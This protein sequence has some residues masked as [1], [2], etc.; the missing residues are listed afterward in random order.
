M[1][2]PS[3]TPQQKAFVLA[4]VLSRPATVTRPMF[5]KPQRITN[6][7]WAFMVHACTVRNVREAERQAEED[8]LAEQDRLRRQQEFVT[9][10]PMGG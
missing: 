1:Q 5:H 10:Q 6:N 9:F 3:L 2:S 4:K 8:R 7:A